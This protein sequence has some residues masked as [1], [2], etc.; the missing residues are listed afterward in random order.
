MEAFP[1]LQKTLAMQQHSSWLDSDENS[2][3]WYK[4]KISAME[5]S[6]L[7]KDMSKDHY[8]LH[9]SSLKEN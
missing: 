7:S 2:D 3:K 5:R 9:W 1:E 8:S 4:D 6:I